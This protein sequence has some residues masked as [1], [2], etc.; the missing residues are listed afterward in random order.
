MRGSFLPLSPY[1]FTRLSETDT[2]TGMKPSLADPV[3][4]NTRTHSLTC[5]LQEHMEAGGMCPLCSSGTVH[6][7]WPDWHENRWPCW[8]E[9]RLDHREPFTPADVAAVVVESH[10]PIMF[11]S[12]CHLDTSWKLGRPGV[13]YRCLVAGSKEESTR[14]NLVL[15][16][17]DAP[18]VAS[19]LRLVHSTGVRMTDLTVV[20]TGAC[21]Q[22][23]E[24]TL[25][26]RNLHAYLERATL[27]KLTATTPG[28]RPSGG[29]SVALFAGTGVGGDHFP[30]FDTHG[31]LVAEPDSIPRGTNTAA[32]EWPQ[33]EPA[34]AA[35]RPSVRFQGLD[36]SSAT[37][38]K[39]AVPISA[40]VEFLNCTGT[41][42]LP[43][44]SPPVDR[45]TIHTSID[46][47]L[48]V[49][50]EGWSCRYIHLSLDSSQRTIP[51]P[52]LG[53]PGYPLADLSGITLLDAVGRPGITVEWGDSRL[54][55]VQRL[56]GLDIKSD[57]T[58]PITDVVPVDGDACRFTP[59]GYV[60]RILG[61]PPKSPLWHATALKQKGENSV[62]VLPPSCC[63][64]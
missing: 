13:A 39:W 47:P 38:A 30:S 1:L 61:L 5:T 50:L 33:I 41:W 54:I 63:G 18:D 7:T 9:L 6:S 57:D 49:S 40:D 53:T 21:C 48:S 11:F 51:L 60:T 44:G 22:P 43:L 2:E 35:V 34:C 56:P 19:D 15:S 36:V 52:V 32:S 16:L 26:C 45:I 59:S 14:V 29:L 20:L 58:Q 46:A 64:H 55:L 25:A 8:I 4:H 24:F 62:R 23:T 17:H 37:D 42:R 10:K 3:S 31:A 27:G 28:G 12:G